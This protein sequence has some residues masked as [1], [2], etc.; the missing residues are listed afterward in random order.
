MR[1][2]R[3]KNDPAG[4][5]EEVVMQPWKILVIDDEPSVHTLTQLILKR[6][7]FAGRK[8]QLLSAFSA[9]EAKE[10]LSRE[11]DIAVALVDVVMESE[12]AGLDLVEYIREELC[13]RHVRL[14]IRTGQAGSAPEREVIDHYDIDDYKD[15]TELTAQ[16]LYTAIRSALK[17]Y[18]DIMIID[19]NRQGLE[20]ILNATPGLYLP[21]FESIDQFFQG[22]LQQLIGLCQLGKNGLLCT[23]NG[24]IST[25]DSNHAQFRAGTG[26]F[27]QQKNN[28]QASECTDIIQTCSNIIK[29]GREPRP[30]E[31]KP[32][33]LLLPL[34]NKQQT[35]GF[36]YLEN[37][38]F[39]SD[40]DQHLIQVLV[41]QCSAALENLKLHFELK[42]ANRD[43]LYMLAVAAEFKDKVTGAHIQRIA[44]YTR[45]L[46]EE[47]GMPED[48]VRNLAQSSMLHDIGKLGIPDAILLK[49]GGLN[50]TELDVMRDHTT[51]GYRI[52]EKHH[53]F[54]Q[55]REIALNHH[56]RWDGTG[57]PRG[58]KGEE[59]PL[60]A[61]IVSVADVYDALLHERPYKEAWTPE[62]CIETLQANAG[63]QF[64]PTVV[65]AFVRLAERGIVPVQLEKT[66]PEI[67]D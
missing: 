34:G 17:A 63:T 2:V 28:D 30:G 39:L 27:V 5:H 49:K 55:A 67:N 65:A 62:R 64:D 40:D 61:R 37:T 36:I 12:H 13:N 41:N 50:K 35:P 26:D 43:S 44:E 42:E 24:F 57:Y 18:R 1:L 59:I 51:L 53:G 52:L 11:S 32:G 45:L 19:S 7:E 66:S 48:E 16:K 23:V 58:L 38:H 46:A 10:V 20:C 14:V 4:P 8:V 6:M 25:F 22:V 47:M 56:E 31:L 3:K 60:T 9:Q 29:E 33:S 54:Q 15:K 21:N